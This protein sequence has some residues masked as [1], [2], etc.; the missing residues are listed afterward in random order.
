MTYDD[1]TYKVHAFTPT[2]IKQAKKIGCHMP[3][4]PEC[5]QSERGALPARSNCCLAGLRAGE[6]FVMVAAARYELPQHCLNGRV[7][8]LAVVDYAFVLGLVA[9][10]HDALELADLG[11]VRKHP[12]A[13]CKL[14]GGSEVHKQLRLVVA[15]GICGVVKFILHPLDQPPVVPVQHGALKA[16][17]A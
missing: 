9:F 3:P 14:D 15:H 12:G 16:G 5:L 17:D 7:L 4:L 10:V 6:R 11:L 2:V 1:D 8:L 13:L